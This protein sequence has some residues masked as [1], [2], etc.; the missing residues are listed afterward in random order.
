MALFFKVLLDF[1]IRKKAIPIS[2]YNTVHAGPNTHE[3][4]LNEG[5]FKEPYHPVTEEEVKNPPT[6]PN[7]NGNAIEST[8]LINDFIDKSTD[9]ILRNFL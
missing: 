4:G 1:Q 5:F 9:Y 8:I 3:G 7:P 2:I 6:A